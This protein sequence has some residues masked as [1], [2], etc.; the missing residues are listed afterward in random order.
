[1][2]S[3]LL[4]H[5]TSHPTGSSA[6]GRIRIEVNGESVEL[7]ATANVADVLKACAIAGRVAV[8]VNREVVRRGHYT[9]HPVADGDRIEILEAVGGG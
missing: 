8:A 4:P 7:S 1:M 2:E 5:S 6:S 9:E 3:P